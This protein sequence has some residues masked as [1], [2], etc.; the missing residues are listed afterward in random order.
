MNISELLKDKHYKFLYAAYIAATLS[1]GAGRDG[2]RHGCV[3]SYKKNTL[4]V[5]FNEFKTHPK[6]LLFSK[7]PFL[8][9]ESRAILS[10]GL[11]NCENTNLYVVRIMKNKHLGLSKPCPSCQRLI[12]HVGIRKVFYSTYEGYEEYDI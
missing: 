8:H 4:V 6:T 11:D 12:K 9:S 3:I 2:F 5:K 10:L 1:P 7:W